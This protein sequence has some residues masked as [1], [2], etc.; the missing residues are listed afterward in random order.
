MKSISI[1]L[2]MMTTACFCAAQQP[3]AKTLAPVHYVRCGALV[4]P[5]S[6]KAQ[7]NVLIAIQG[8]RIVEVREGAANSSG[9]NVTDLS[10]HTCLPGLIDV[11]DHLTSDPSHSAIRV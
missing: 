9:A 3:E 10:D 11:H 4:Q 6:G 8:E 1:F 7:R 2:L 5:E